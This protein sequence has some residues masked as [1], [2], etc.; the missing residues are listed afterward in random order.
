MTLGRDLYSDGL[1]GWVCNTGQ[2]TST[3]YDNHETLSTQFSISTCVCGTRHHVSWYSYTFYIST[4][5]GDF[6]YNF[7]CARCFLIGNMNETFRT[8]SLGEW[9]DT[10]T[11]VFLRLVAG[12]LRG[13]GICR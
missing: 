13:K 10:H 5:S 6:G 1:F 11:A 2:G 12:G 8:C 7:V 3:R 4:N 9:K